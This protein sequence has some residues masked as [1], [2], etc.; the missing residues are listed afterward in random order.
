M[1]PTILIV[2]SSVA[3]TGGFRAV[4]N[5]AKALAGHADIILALPENSAIDPAEFAPFK[6]V[7]RLPI[8]TLRRSAR[9]VA[10]FLPALLSSA[11]ALR[12]VLRTEATHLFVND[13]T[14][15][16]GAMLRA[17]GYRGFVGAWIRIS[18]LSFPASVS[19]F[20]LSQVWRS[21]DRIVAVSRHAKALVPPSP[22]LRVIYDP[23]APPAPVVRVSD[24]SKQVMVYIANFIRGKGQEHAI[25]AFALIAERHPASELHFWGGD[26]GLDKNR[27][28]LGEL[29][30]QSRAVGLED[31]I[32]FQ[33]YAADLQIA[34]S[35]ADLA[36]ALSES[37]TLS[38][39]CIEA[40][41]AGLPVIATRCGGP[42]EIVVDGETGFLVPRGDVATIADRMT[43]LLDDPASA[44]R[45]GD[46]GA[47]LSARIFSPEVFR[48]VFMDAIGA[49]AP[50]QAG[51]MK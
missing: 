4:S 14:L 27:A 20:L 40:S 15:M 3:M 23:V 37:E 50:G 51:A 6:R 28:F 32:V 26:M 10:A 30:M 12:R 44:R 17:L 18:P 11:L 41:L 39:T 9:D 1:R 36:L 45:M 42:E 16:H 34:L 8:R 47:R 25:A 43:R 33:G 19:R 5:A 2:D 35:R 22:Q 38:L 48:A 13:F 31:R 29:K 21:S 7:I 49:D 24:A 46:A